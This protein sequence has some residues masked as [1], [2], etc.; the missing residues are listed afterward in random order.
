M[1]SAAGRVLGFALVMMLVMSVVGLSAAQTF[2]NKTGKTVTGIK[3]EFS[4]GVL[5]TRHDSVFPDQSP[6]GR[7][8]EFTFDSGSLRNLGR[9]T[10]TWMPSSGKVRD[11]EWIEKAQPEQ[12]SQT[13]SEGESTLPDPNTPPILYGN[14]YPGPNEPKYQ[15]AP[16]EQIWLTDLE[17]HGDI[18]DNNSIK[19]NYAPGFDASQITK[20]SVYRNGVY[21]RFLTE[22]FEVLTNA[23]MKTFDGNPAEH[24]PATRHTDH[25]IMGYEYEFK[26]ST[27]DHLWILKKT[28]KSGFKWRPKEVWADIQHNWPGEMDISYPVIVD[29]FK[30]LRE[31]GITGI[32]V[33]I[34]HYMDTPY[35]N[36]VKRLSHPDISKL[37]G[38]IFTPSDEQLNVL[39]KAINC[40]GL[41][42]QAKAHINISVTYC[43]QYG[44][45]W[46]ASVD[47]NDSRAFFDSYTKLMLEL[48]PIL[49][50]YH[51]KLFT[52]L[53]EPDTLEQ[54]YPHLIRNMYTAISQVY[55]GG[56]GLDEST[57]NMLL[58]IGPINDRVILTRDAFERLVRG[59]TFWDWKDV[60]GTPMRIEYS[61][62]GFPMDVQSDQRAS[63]IE[64]KW[65]QFWPLVI[66]Y[67]RQAHPTNIQMWGE[68]GAR[69]ADGYVLGPAYYSIINKVSDEQERADV[70]Y[71]MLKA[72]K[73]LEITRMNIF[74]FLLADNAPNWENGVGMNVGYNLPASPEYRIIKAIIAPEE[75]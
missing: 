5:I 45:S 67:N 54:K 36:G 16:D 71:G 6:S 65:E 49:N 22:K 17:G 33:P 11:Y 9:F 31:D 18:Y 73:E 51:V 26:I 62:W 59:F 3:I 66:M 70:I 1:K 38:W 12:T 53:T 52:P 63:V 34:Y 2:I 27:A 43:N 30:T 23:Q 24:S 68:V 20:I 44:F 15:P 75:E 60:H 50:K 35:D 46:S 29:F 13:S 61:T 10:V 21:M 39:F 25:A 72:S 42:I 69:D 19:I 41:E 56:L 32:T 7:S 48:V 4:R 40:A 57:H 37:V 8:D 28:V 74:G 14:D 58:G 64:S 47:P 55:D